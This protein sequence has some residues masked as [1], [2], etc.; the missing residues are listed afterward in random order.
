MSKINQIKHQQCGGK[1]YVSYIYIKLFSFSL[2]AF[3][4]EGQVSIYIYFLFIIE[5]KKT[6]QQQQQRRKIVKEEKLLCL[7]QKL[8][9][10]YLCAR[11]KKNE[12]KMKGKYKV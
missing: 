10:R 2:V 5:K 1:I 7:L 3:F 8:Y 9:V 11:N 12:D 4:F 6:H